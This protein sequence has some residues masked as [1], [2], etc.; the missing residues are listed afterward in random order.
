MKK[1][2]LIALVIGTL[3]IGYTVGN[4]LRTYLFPTTG[5]IATISLSITWL[6]GTAVTAID[7]GVT[8]NGTA[9]IMEPINITNLSNIPVNLTLSMLNPSLS[10][11]S[12]SLTWNYIGSILQPNGWIIVELEQTVTATGPYS[13]DTVITATEAP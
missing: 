1:L 13:Y 6:N 11:I 2:V 4:L 9:Y 7:W 10:I 8:E 3:L 12:L 5:E